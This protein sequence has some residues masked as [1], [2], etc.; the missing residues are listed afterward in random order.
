MEEKDT[1][2]YKTLYFYLFNRIS[3]LNE[4]I[5]AQ[6]DEADEK[7]KSFMLQL[8]L[9]QMEAEEKYLKLA[10]NTETSN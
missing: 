7:T 3:K 9:M 8:R 5:A 2:D 1:I 4:Q 6:A 10:E